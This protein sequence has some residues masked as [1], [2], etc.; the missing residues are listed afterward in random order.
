MGNGPLVANPPSA[1][2]DR[3]AF[4][5]RFDC[6]KMNVIVDPEIHAFTR[7]VLRQ[8]EASHPNE[9]FFFDAWA[10]LCSGDL[11]ALS[12][13]GQTFYKDQH[14]LTPYGALWLQ[15]HAFAGL[16]LFLLEALQTAATN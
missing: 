2:F 14:H 3:P 1:C 16:S 12:D 7:R 13:G 10:H 8:I 15:H 6:S 9:V 4:F 11:C 5:G